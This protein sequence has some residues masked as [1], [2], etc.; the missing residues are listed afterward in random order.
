MQEV[1]TNILGIFLG[2]LLGI[3]A[4]LALNHAWDKRVDASRRKQLLSALKG[5][6]DKNGYLIGQ[7]HEW[8]SKSGGT[9]FFNLD[10]TLLES[11]ATI[12]YDLLADID[13]CREIDYLR[14]EL[15][16]LSRKVDILL[17]LEFNPSS[18]MAIDAPE[19]SMYYKLRPKLVQ[20]I[21]SHIEPIKKTVEQ[22]QTKLQ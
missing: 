19:G 1:I 8:V 20:A 7:I 16:H 22:L 5:A 17:D 3:P 18:R 6:V 13:L 11:T 9:P 14:F 4:G 15:T 12:K 2:A 21:S 10:L